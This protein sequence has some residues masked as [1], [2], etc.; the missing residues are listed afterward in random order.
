M[1]EEK[2][3][4]KKRKLIV[5]IHLYAVTNTNRSPGQKIDLIK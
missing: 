3:Q 1:T 2:N 5:I 4:R